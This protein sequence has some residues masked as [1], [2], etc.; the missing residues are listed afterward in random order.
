MDTK[1]M[2]DQATKMFDNTK[3]WLDR[4]ITKFNDLSLWDK[5]IVIVVLHY[6]IRFFKS[7]SGE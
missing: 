5:I 6:G 3:G 1:S 4:Q 7:K 2:K